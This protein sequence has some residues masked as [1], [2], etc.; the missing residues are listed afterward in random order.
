VMLHRI[1]GLLLMGCATQE[2]R[3][4][5]GPPKPA[6]PA[7]IEVGNTTGPVELERSPESAAGPAPSPQPLPERTPTAEPR[8]A[9]AD[10]GPP[11]PGI[12]VRTD[13]GRYLKPTCFLGY[14]GDLK[15]SVLLY[16]RPE[17]YYRVKEFLGDGGKANRQRAAAVA[18]ELEVTAVNPGGA[19]DVLDAHPDGLFRIEITSGDSS[20]L[21]GWVERH[22]VGQ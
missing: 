17:D 2:V 10:P 3:P 7:V 20:G 6:A 8:Q 14:Q 19:C 18:R 15:T 9:S 4:P 11:G 21:G 22:A 12:W 1:L 5:P 16:R 13:D